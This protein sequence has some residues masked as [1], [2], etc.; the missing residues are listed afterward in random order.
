M[1]GHQN[2]PPPADDW[3]PAQ[4]REVATL[5]RRLR[6]RKSRRRFL[7]AAGTI[8]GTLL[9]GLGGWWLVQL[10]TRQ[11]EYDFGGITCSEVAARADALMQGKLAEDEVARVKQHV[12]LCPHCKPWFER[13]GALKLLAQVMPACGRPETM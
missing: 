10:A 13:M 5:A 12:L 11:R 6:G 2:Q 4:G 7:V 8:G 3:Q 9:A 1:T